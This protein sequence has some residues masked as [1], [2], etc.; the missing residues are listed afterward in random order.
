[1]A[2]KRKR[3]YD[4]ETKEDA[5]KQAGYVDLNPPQIEGAH[6]YSTKNQLPWDIQP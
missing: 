6:L 5:T 3:V 4:G 2:K 1:M